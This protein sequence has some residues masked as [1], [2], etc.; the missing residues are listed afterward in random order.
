MVEQNMSSE[1]SVKWEF[2]ARFRKGCFGWKSAPAI[3]RIKEAVTEISK[4][5][6][7]DQ[8]LGA[9]G[10]V[11][12][13][14]KLSPALEK[15]D[16]SSG[17]IGAAVYNALKKLTPIIASAPAGEKLRE[18]WL[19]R[20]WEAVQNDDIPYIEVLADQWGDL[21]GSPLVAS[22][23]ADQFIGTVRMVWGSNP[24]LRGHF[25]GTP[26]CLSSLSAAGR[27]EELLELLE[28]M[29]Y[30]TWH[31]RQWGVKALAALGKKT[32]ALLYAEDSLGRND[33]PVGMARLCEE[34]LLADGSLDEAYRRYAIMANGKGTYLATFRAIA[35]KYPHKQPREILMDLAASS[36]GEE[37]K[38]FAAAKSAGLY[39]EAVELANSSPC[40][41]K[42]LTRAARDM[43]ETEPVFALEAGM[44]ALK[45]LV[46]GYGYDV[47]G[48]DVL[49]AY[50][51]TMNA[52]EAV[53]RKSETF[54]RIRTLV[55]GEV[56]GEFIVTKILGATLGLNR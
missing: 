23:W 18:S 43:A 13:L 1:Q 41:P 28:Q 44:T 8:I 9:T 17:A 32:E 55:A 50:S 10:A 24:G 51:S 11:L 6:R 37:G 21:C 22:L 5:A 54:E 3:A 35:K 39:P 14:E 38:W 42:T 4:A 7:K 12:L 40:D 15:V 48:G 46:A 36:P 29:P 19:E 49:S 52:A 20:L 30:K 56:F 34:L 53:D 16:S 26:A 45:W 33:N 2:S 31:Y 27:N 25:K 47:T